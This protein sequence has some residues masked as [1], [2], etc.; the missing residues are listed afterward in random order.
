M[1]NTGNN[2]ERLELLFDRFYKNEA[3]KEERE[4][5]ALLL[6]ENQYKAHLHKLL[7]Q[8]WDKNEEK[9]LFSQAQSNAI[10]STILGPTKTKKLVREK[11]FPTYMPYLRI[12]AVAAAITGIIIIGYLQNFTKNANK[13]VHNNK[14]VVIATKPLQNTA[15]AKEGVILTLAD[16]RQIVLDS[17]GKGLLTNQGNIQV[18]KQDGQIS[19]KGQGEGT[20]YNTMT[21]PRAGQYSLI[22]SD[23]SKVWLN[24]A[25]SIRFPTAF[26]GKERQV[27][28][29]GEAY[30]E[31][32]HDPSKPF[33]AI[34]DDMDVSV[35]GT[36]FNVN[37]YQDESVIKTTLLEGKVS[38][39]N[40][41]STAVLQPG[42]QAQVKGSDHLEVVKEVNVEDVIAWKNGLFSLNGTDVETLMKRI[43]RWYDIEVVHEG[44]WPQ[45]RFV[46]S[47]SRSVNLSD[48]VKALKEF[49]INC[50]LENRKLII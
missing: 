10:F 50:R 30:F 18:T 34:V 1:E 32:A 2:V 38:I 31:I 23:G 24:A 13:E 11:T 41:S 20:V 17:A 43:S 21:T 46:G 4:E 8:A 45:K 6:M 3:S 33:H 40:G 19:Y 9:S 47:I 44:P 42:E 7:K 14:E 49:G 25:S 12:F 35:L 22:L 39:K 26:I 48:L 37:A 16:G 5:L 15:P 27:Q 36:H 28:I 29:T